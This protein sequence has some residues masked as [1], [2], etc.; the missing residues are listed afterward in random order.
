[1]KIKLIK[2]LIKKQEND[3]VI[4]HKSQMNNMIYAS[5]SIWYT[6]TILIFLGCIILGFGLAYLIIRLL[7][8]LNIK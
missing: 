1:M 5:Q 6:L 3:C 4:S 7:I 2:K 8:N